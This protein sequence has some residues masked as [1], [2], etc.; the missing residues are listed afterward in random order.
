MRRSYAEVSEKLHEYETWGVPLERQFVKDIHD[1]NRGLVLTQTGSAPENILFA[2][3]SGRVEL[4]TSLAITN[5]SPRDIRVTEI[6]LDLPFFAPDF[7]LIQLPPRAAGQELPAIGTC[8]FEKSTLLNARLGP[9]F[10]I[11]SGLSVDGLLLGEGSGMVPKEYRQGATVGV[12]LTVFA[13]RGRRYAI[14]IALRVERQDH[15]L[16]HT[17][18]PRRRRL[19]EPDELDALHEHDERVRPLVRG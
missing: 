8:P 18:R 15:A 6:Q 14:W 10:L 7:H 13:S 11:S 19:L 1:G 5:I 2:T 3:K 4:I 9:R 16:S 12:G 17:K